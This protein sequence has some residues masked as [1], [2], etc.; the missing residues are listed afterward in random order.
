MTK[1][2]MLSHSSSSTE[3]DNEPFPETDLI[4]H[5]VLHPDL[6]NEPYSY[7]DNGVRPEILCHT[8]KYFKY[9]IYDDGNAICHSGKLVI[10]HAG[11]NNPA[12]VQVRRVTNTSLIDIYHTY[13]LSTMYEHLRDLYDM[14]DGYHIHIYV[15]G[16]LALIK[17]KYALSLIMEKEDGDKCI[18]AATR[19]MISYLLLELLS[20]E[21]RRPRLLESLVPVT[22]TLPD[23][24]LARL[25]GGRISRG[26]REKWLAYQH[27]LPIREGE[28]E[29]RA[30]LPY[31]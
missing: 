13:G 20:L 29:A 30:E 5:C 31:V 25:L 18:Y 26:L 14:A 19:A 15:A 9:E 28:I 21:S 22:I 12:K 24:I 3:E 7:H 17:P 1:V 27:S 6:C 4:P 16:S 8:Q 2:R 23:D 11:L 10:G